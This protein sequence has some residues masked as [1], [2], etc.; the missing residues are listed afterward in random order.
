[1]PSTLGRLRLQ[2]AHALLNPR[3]GERLGRPTVSR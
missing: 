2:T 3:S 1:L